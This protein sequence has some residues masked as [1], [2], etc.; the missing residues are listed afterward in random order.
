MDRVHRLGQYKPIRVVR[1]VIADTIEE[2]ILRLQRKK[3]LVFDS[4]VGQ[5]QEAL[6]RLTEEDMRFLFN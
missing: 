5:S 2:R 3:Q 4:T 1:F 6:A